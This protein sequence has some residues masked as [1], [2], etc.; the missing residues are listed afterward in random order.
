MRNQRTICS[1]IGDYQD[2]SHT[3][4][5]EIVLSFSMLSSIILGVRGDAAFHLTVLSLANWGEIAQLDF[6]TRPTLLRNS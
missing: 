5:Q 1:A 2:V 4:Q 6:L 3:L